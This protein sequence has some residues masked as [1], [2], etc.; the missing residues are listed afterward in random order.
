MLSSEH[1]P[2]LP[3]WASHRHG[4]PPVGISRPEHWDLRTVAADRVKL[5]GQR[6]GR[7]RDNHAACR[8]GCLAV[9]GCIG[10]ICPPPQRQAPTLSGVTG[11]PVCQDMIDVGPHSRRTKEKRAASLVDRLL[12]QAED[13][14]VQGRVGRRNGEH[15]DVLVAHP[16]AVWATPVD[17]VAEHPVTWP[18][19]DAAQGRAI[20]RT[21]VCGCI[22]SEAAAVVMA[23]GDIRQDLVRI[24]GEYR[25]HGDR[26]SLRYQRG[27]AG[28]D[29]DNRVVK[30]RRYRKNR[31][32]HAEER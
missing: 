9:Q 30:V 32:V 2:W 12:K 5:R 27:Q 24:A 18:G 8:F 28:A 22:G 15:I 19:T 6:G 23:L 21:P 29:R 17:G 1:L 7:V 16:C 10:L 11:G 26:P 4:R 3:G 31:P 14:G 13:A 25:E 20:L